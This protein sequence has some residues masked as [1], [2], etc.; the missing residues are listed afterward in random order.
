MKGRM[1]Y[2]DKHDVPNKYI[3]LL[4]NKKAPLKTYHFFYLI[5]FEE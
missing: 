1:D 2:S 4:G 3:A 5:L